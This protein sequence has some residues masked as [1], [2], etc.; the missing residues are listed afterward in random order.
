MSSEIATTD[1]SGAELTSFDASLEAERSAERTVTRSIVRS[2]VILV[3]IM[4][5]F[6]IGL[7]ALAAGDDL[8]IWVIIGIGSLLGLIGAVLFGML[9]GVTMSAHAFDDVDRGVIGEH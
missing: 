5:A 8:G 6:F 1:G 2:V 9:A 4:I 7:I 3:P